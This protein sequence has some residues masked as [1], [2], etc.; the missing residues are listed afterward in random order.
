ML[1]LG[2]TGDE[3]FDESVVELFKLEGCKVID[4]AVDAINVE[5]V[6]PIRGRFLEI[7]QV[8]SGSFVMDHFGPLKL[9]PRP[10]HRVGVGV[11][12]RSH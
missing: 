1:A 8:S 4:R 6:N 7:V 3:V 12:D 9:D 5:S 11:A 10:R 2:G